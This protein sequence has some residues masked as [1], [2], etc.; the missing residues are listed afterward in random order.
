MTSYCEACLKIFPTLLILFGLFGCTTPITSEMPTIADV[1][2]ATIAPL[3]F[4]A[5]SLPQPTQTQRPTRTLIPIATATPS[6]DTKPAFTRTSKPLATISPEQIDINI[7]LLLQKSSGC[8]FPCVW[9]ITPGE[10]SR[11]DAEQ[12]LSKNGVNLSSDPFR[13]WTEFYASVMTLDKISVQLAFYEREDTVEVVSLHGEGVYTPSVFREKWA[14]YSPENII[15]TYGSPSRVWIDADSNS[16]DSPSGN[17]LYSLWLFYD[18]Q[19]FLL[20]YYG[21]TKG[22]PSLKLCPT[23]REPGNLG[24]VGYV[25]DIYTKSPQV[26]QPLEDIAEWSSRYPTSAI[27]LEDAAEMTIDEFYALYQ[28]E[29]K[30]ICIETPWDIWK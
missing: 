27:N 5:T 21:T 20:R 11:M 12:I 18:P 13:D 14:S 22:S 10:T 2:T 25:L 9:G 3:F 4:T 15:L 7:Y 16:G 26:I 30:P 19:G 29:D 6:P 17:V 23:F 8:E 28:Q 1:A 24:A